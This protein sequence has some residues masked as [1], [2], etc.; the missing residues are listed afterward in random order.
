MLY[1][2]YYCST[3]YSAELYFITSKNHRHRGSTRGATPTTPLILRVDGKQLVLTAILS[4]DVFTFSHKVELFAIKT[5][6]MWITLR[7]TRR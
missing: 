1:S 6:V 5:C 7:E 2:V 4:K 3:F